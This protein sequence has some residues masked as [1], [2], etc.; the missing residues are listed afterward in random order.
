MAGQQTMLWLKLARPPH[1]A[2]A[3][4]GWRGQ[5]DVYEIKYSVCVCPCLIKSLD[6]W[7]FVP[8]VY[9]SNGKFNH[10]FRR[11]LL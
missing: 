5:N 10:L 7:I 6:D 11:D 1:L 8:V 4:C 9:P 3:I 2:F